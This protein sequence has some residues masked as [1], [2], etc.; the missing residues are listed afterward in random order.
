M[1]VAEAIRDIFMETEGTFLL[2]LHKRLLERIPGRSRK[3][4]TTV[5]LVHLLKKMGLVEFA[6][7]GPASPLLPRSYYIVVPGTE[8]DPRWM[9]YPFHVIYPATR[10]GLRYDEEKEAG[11]EPR[12]RSPEYVD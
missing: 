11:R 9:E 4:T 3:Y 8:F 12:G 7:H 10:L 6:Y 1:K 2:D 5:R